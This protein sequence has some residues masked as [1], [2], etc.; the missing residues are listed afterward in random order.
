MVRKGARQYQRDGRPQWKKVRTSWWC[1]EELETYLLGPADVVSIIT[2][3]A[4]NACDGS[5]HRRSE[6]VEKT[7]N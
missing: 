1:V 4:E 3:L 5:G 6:L 2:A 7:W